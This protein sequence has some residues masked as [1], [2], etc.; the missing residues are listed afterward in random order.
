[1]SQNRTLPNTGWESTVQWTAA[2]ESRKERADYYLKNILED[3]VSWYSKKA[4]TRKRLHFLFAF[5]VM[6]GGTVIT[7]LQAV[8]SQFV[9]YFTALLGALVTIIR[10]L[11]TLIRPGETWRTYRRAEETIKRE[12]RF[13]INDTEAYAEAAD[14]V[15]AY[16]LFVNRVELAIAEESQVFWQARGKTLGRAAEDSTPS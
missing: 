2:I 1:M 11:D 12:Y 7:G 15:A 6:I 5:L 8:D 3:Q 10:A 14:E 9:R 4:N 13:Y 16:H